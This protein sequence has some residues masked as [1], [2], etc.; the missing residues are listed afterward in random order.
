[1]GKTKKSKIPAVK[2]VQAVTETMP[3][4]HRYEDTTTHQQIMPYYDRA[5]TN[6]KPPVEDP[7]E[8]RIDWRSINFS[9]QLLKWIM[10]NE[11]SVAR[12]GEAGFRWVSM[13]RIIAG[14]LGISADDAKQT[15]RNYKASGDLHVVAKIEGTRL[16]SASPVEDENTIPTAQN[17]AEE[18]G[19]NDALFSQEEK[20]IVPEIF[21]RLSKANVD[22]GIK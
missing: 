5:R 1:T 22:L 2:D 6:T 3:K 13:S 7:V 18:A 8:A 19:G 16:M 11:E 10:A 21:V 4:S 17:Y 9:G 12:E 15:L 20:V 14:Q